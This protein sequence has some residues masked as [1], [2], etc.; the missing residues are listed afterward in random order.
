MEVIYR[1]GQATATEVLERMPGPALLLLRAGAPLRILE[2]KGHLR[3]VVDGTR[4]V[5]LPDGR[6]RARAPLRDAEPAPDVLRGL[7]RESGRGSARRFPLRAF[8]G[9]PRPDLPADRKRPRGGALTW[10]TIAL[11]AIR[12]GLDAT[13]KAT[14]LLALVL[15]LAA[16]D[17]ASPRP[18]RHLL[19][20]LGLA[21]ALRSRSR[22]FSFRP[23]R[24]RSCRASCPASAGRRREIEDPVHPRGPA[25]PV[26]AAPDADTVV[27]RAI[28]RA[29][30]TPRS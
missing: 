6:A 28:S 24:S 9:G 17:R 18:A 1:A 12:F 14:F 3:H 2:T 11:F 7:A 16:C 29:S 23:S 15:L 30:R 26:E 21:G 4:Y 13:I 19:A 8:G 10:N 25:D 5:F 20:M 27:V 22:R